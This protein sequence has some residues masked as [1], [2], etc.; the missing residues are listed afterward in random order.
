LAESVEP[1]HPARNVTAAEVGEKDD[2]E[3]SNAT[4]DSH[5]LHFSRGR[6]RRVDVIGVAQRRACAG[7]QSRQQHCHACSSQPT[8][9]GGAELHAAEL[10]LLAGNYL[11]SIG[12]DRNDVG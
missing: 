2:G 4:G 9:E 3:Q 11:S 6:V 10:F 7:H 12:N 8:E 5:T 1:S